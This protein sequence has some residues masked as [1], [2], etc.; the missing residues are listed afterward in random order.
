VAIA[1][2]TEW[3]DLITLSFEREMLG[4]YVTGHPLMKYDRL[5]E[6][7]AN[8]TTVA[9]AQNGAP[10]QVKIAGLVKNIK[11]INTKKGDRMAF[12]T[13]EDLEGTA[14]VTIFSDLYAQAQEL[15][16]SGKPLL[17]SGNR[18]GDQENPKILAQEIHSLED[19]PRRL[20]NALHIRISTTGTDPLQIKE[21]SRILRK[22]QGRVPVKL[23]VVIPNR[24]ETIISVPSISCDPSEE[25][26][27]QVKQTFGYQPI[28]FE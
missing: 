10:S 5:I 4:F 9:L 6:R 26:L 19:A 24:T 23:H 11:E 3:A 18:E 20:S 13:L 7:Y 14:E 21:L 17:V 15:L 1:E 12:V 2:L 8:A 22:H 27:A 25:M 16:R 28:S